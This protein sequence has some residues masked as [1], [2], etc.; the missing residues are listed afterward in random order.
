MYLCIE[1]S[2]IVIAGVY[3]CILHSP[4]GKCVGKEIRKWKNAEKL[5]R[6]NMFVYPC[7]KV[8]NCI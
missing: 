1:D 2:P 3:I 4:R 6:C 5:F 8:C 7:D